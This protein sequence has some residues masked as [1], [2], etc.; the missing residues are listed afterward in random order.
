M[1]SFVAGWADLRNVPQP[2]AHLPWDHIRILIDKLDEQDDLEQPLMDRIVDTLRERGAGFAFVD[3]QMHFEVDDDDVHLD[4]LFFH[5][6]Q[7]RYV[8]VELKAS[9]FQPE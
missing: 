2:V 6:N 7:L 3:R 9:K 8:V 5:V 1:R 4:L